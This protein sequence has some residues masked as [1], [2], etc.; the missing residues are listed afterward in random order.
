MRSFT[1]AASA[2]LEVSNEIDRRYRGWKKDVS[3]PLSECRFYPVPI[4]PLS[5]PLQSVE[6]TRGKKGGPAFP[7]QMILEDR[8]SVDRDGA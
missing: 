1:S 6:T 4:T 8:G 5:E 2:Y 3:H 7:K